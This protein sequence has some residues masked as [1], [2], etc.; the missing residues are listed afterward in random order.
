MASRIVVLSAIAV[1]GL[2]S[3]AHADR[4]NYAWTYQYMTMAKRA[5]EIEFYQTTSF[6]S[7]DFWE[8]RLELEH[9]FTERWDFS[10]YQI[11]AQVEG[12]NLLWDAVQFRTRYRF[13]EEGQYLLDP[14]LYLEYRRKL[15][16]RR[17]HK[18]ETR[19]V[20]ARTIS[21]FNV[22]LNPVYELF[23]APGVEH[24]VGLDVAACW[25]FNPAISVGFESVSR[26]ELKGEDTE[27][28]SYLGPA[29]SFASGNWWYT[30]GLGVGLTA[31]SH[32]ARARFLMGIRF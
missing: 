23:V 29:V 9:G 11:F 24:E 20:L 10:V 27:L 22:A 15:D 7:R 28:A 1:L 25:E 13:G 4:R 16:S 26:L 18:L 3:A 6:G 21:K 12:G 17:P 32:D 5:T 2:G 31:D 14:L 8:F 19:L 30:I